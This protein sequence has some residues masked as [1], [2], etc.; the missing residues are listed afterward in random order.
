MKKEK[1]I[2]NAKRSAST[3]IRKVWEEKKKQNH[4]PNTKKVG[5]CQEQAANEGLQTSEAKTM[6]ITQCY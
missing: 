2:E 5:I 4:V 6:K 3:P 1:I